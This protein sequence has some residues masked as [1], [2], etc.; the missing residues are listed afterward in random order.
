MQ[1]YI[2]V[3]VKKT[4]KQLGKKGK[5][6]KL[7]PGYIFNYLIP[8][9]LVE[10]PT[11]GKLKHFAMFNSIEDRKKQT[12]ILQAKNIKE[13]IEMI[14]KISIT[15]KI[16]DKRQIFGSINEKEII[17]EIYKQTNQI[18]EKKYIEIPLIKTIGLFSLP[19]KL[20]NQQE[21]NLII[22]VLPC[23]I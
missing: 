10:I 1:K 18:I 20:L 8:N 15:K 13:K 22:Q 2:T 19:I 9:D 4:H 6:L 7:A 14:K 21:F 3:I 16:G 5:I 23:N 12:L 11:K 17:N